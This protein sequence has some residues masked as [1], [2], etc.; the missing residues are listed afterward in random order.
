MMSSLY[1]A[2][3]LC[4]ISVYITAAETRILFVLGMCIGL[5]SRFNQESG[6]F[7]SKSWRWPIQWR[8]GVR[9]GER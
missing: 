3:R 2:V 4:L 9:L 5:I 8:L 7:M 6:V 1:K